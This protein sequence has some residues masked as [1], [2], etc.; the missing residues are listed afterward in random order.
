MC[1]YATKF[2]LIS[3][4]Y[5]NNVLLIARGGRPEEIFA[6]FDEKNLS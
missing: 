1:Q 5:N 4:H 2:K 6:G 3:N